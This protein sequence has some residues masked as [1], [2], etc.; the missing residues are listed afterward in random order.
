MGLCCGG[1]LPVKFTH[2]QS[3]RVLTHAAR[4]LASQTSPPALNNAVPSLPRRRP[5][6]GGEGVDVDF[7]VT[8]QAESEATEGEAEVVEVDALIGVIVAD[9]AE[10]AG[11]LEAPR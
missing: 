7:S 9:Q 3:T 2:S 8:A 1:T 11:S 4:P 5:T 6:A 10:A